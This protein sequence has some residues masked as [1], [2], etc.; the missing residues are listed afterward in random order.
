[1][2]EFA[3]RAPC[4]DCG[5]SDGRIDRRGEQNCVF[6]SGC[7][8]FAYNAPKTETGDAPRTVTRVHNGIRPKQ[9]ARLLLRAYGRCELCG[10][11]GPLHIGHLL[12]VEEGLALGLTELELNSDDNLATLCEE[13]N[14]GLG[15]ISVTP[16][17]YVALL[18][19]RR[20]RER[21]PQ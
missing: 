9:R 19:R 5:C 11:V 12:S 7:G 15:S 6:C 21:N 10:G 20:S 4:L 16:G 14:L 17:L 1:M 3:M 8:R 2:A 18:M 13:C